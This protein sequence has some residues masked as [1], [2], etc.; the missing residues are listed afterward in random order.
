MLRELRER[1]QHLMQSTA[2]QG[3]LSH[4]Q[5]A[6]VASLRAANEDLRK[7]LQSLRA[8]R[9]EVIPQ[10]SLMTPLCLMLACKAK[11]CCMRHA[12]RPFKRL[13]Q[14]MRARCRRALEA[15]LI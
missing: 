15:Q 7:E 6:A 14:V 5:E 8:D 1:M 9:D 12:A 10:L 2:T 3:S 13:L 11:V 4:A